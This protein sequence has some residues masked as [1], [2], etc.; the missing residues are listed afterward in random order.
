MKEKVLLV[1]A[2]LFSVF[3]MHFN[4]NEGFEFEKIKVYISFLEYG[5]KSTEL[6]L[7][8]T[9][10]CYI[11]LLLFCASVW[12]K[13]KKSAEVLLYLLVI[14]SSFGLV[15]EFSILYEYF[16]EV[17]RGKHFRISIILLLWAIRILYKTEKSKLVPPTS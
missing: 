1:L 3:I 15:Y 13:A 14:V 17:Y 2:A 10:L 9:I 5:T 12:T 11:S 7:T 4:I 16:T 8:S 6:V